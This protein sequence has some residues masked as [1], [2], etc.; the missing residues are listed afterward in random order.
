MF[1]NY[2]RLCNYGLMENVNAISSSGSVDF[3][4]AALDTKSLKSL[5]KRSLLRKETFQVAGETKTSVLYLS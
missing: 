1:P 4:I 3:E 5:K 2:L